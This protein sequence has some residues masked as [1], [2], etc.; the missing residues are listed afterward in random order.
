MTTRSKSIPRFGPDGRSTCLKHVLEQVL[1]SDPSSPLYISVLQHFGNDEDK[2]N[3]IDYFLCDMTF[4]ENL[5][6]MET[7]ID[8][9][10]ETDP[11]KVISRL[12]V[13]PVPNYLRARCIFFKRF[14]EDKKNDGQD[15]NY[16]SFYMGLTLDEFMTWKAT[17]MTMNTTS[18]CVAKSRDLVADFKK[19][20]K[21]DLSQVPSLK[22]IDNWPTFKHET[23]AQARAQDVVDVFNPKYKPR[24]SEERE[25]FALQLYYV[26]AIFCS[27]LK[28]DFGRKLVR[29]HES[30][31]DAQ[32]IWAELSNDAEKSTVAQLNATDLLQYVHTA[33]VENWKGTT[34]SFILHYQE[35][36]WLYDQLQ[37][38]NEQTSDHAKMIYLQNAVYAIE[39]LRSVQTTGSQLALANGT[40]PTYKDYEA[41]LKSAASTYDRAHAPAKRQPTRSV[42]RTDIWDANVTDSFHD[43]Y[44]FGFDIDTPTDIV[45]AHMRDQSGMIATETFGQLSR[46]SRKAWSQLSDEVRTD[47]LRALQKGGQPSQGSS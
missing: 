47:I 14:L 9:P 22:H 19:G 43:A 32:A 7:V 33:R 5:T 2:F 21:R 28:T 41:L 3:V 25:L 17:E 34:L 27:N 26:Y 20:I 6:Y 30:S 39:E 23:M 45:Q 24:G 13:C 12:E 29:D 40:V 36:I 8:N 35:Q 18:P 1:E 4:F 38:P 37:P 46:E 31:Q 44:D 10:N 15:L 42:E 11:T 16:E